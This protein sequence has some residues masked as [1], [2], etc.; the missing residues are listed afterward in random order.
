MTKTATKTAKAKTVKFDAAP[1]FAAGL[2][3]GYSDLSDLSLLKGCPAAKIE[4]A[5]RAYT[6]GYIVS[7]LVPEGKA[8]TEKDR[9]KAQAILDGVGPDSKTVPDGKVKRTAAEHALAR[10]GE[11]KFNRARKRAGVAPASTK[12][13]ARPGTGN[14]VK[15]GKT[16]TAKGLPAQAKTPASAET[17]PL[18]AKAVKDM[19]GIAHRFRATWVHFQKANAELEVSSEARALAVEITA[20]ITAYETALAAAK[21]E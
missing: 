5:K 4:E 9:A 2:K 15:K 10:A 20:K 19:V 1:F 18:K 7:G 14:R 17:F 12:G 16:K 8:V 13:G 21:G 3:S 11:R 6:H